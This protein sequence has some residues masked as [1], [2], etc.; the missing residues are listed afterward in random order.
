MLELDKNYSNRQVLLFMARHGESIMPIN[1]YGSS[2]RNC[3]A[4]QLSIVTYGDSYVPGTIYTLKRLRKGWKV[5]KID[6]VEK[7]VYEKESAERRLMSVMQ[8]VY[9]GLI[10]YDKYRKA[11]ELPKR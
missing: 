9:F 7:Q 6:K 8:S 3:D 1:E 11:H 2:Y 5:T 10:D 4:R